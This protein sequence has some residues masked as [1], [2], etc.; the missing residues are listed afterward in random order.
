MNL[1]AKSLVVGLF[2][3][4]SCFGQM[5]LTELQTRVDEASVKARETNMTQ[6]V[7]VPDGEIVRG[8]PGETLTIKS[9]VFVTTPSGVDRSWRL[10][11]QNLQPGQTAILFEEN[12]YG[13]GIRGCS[14]RCS[15]DTTSGI[16]GIKTLGQ[17]KNPL[18]ENCHV[19]FWRMKDCVALQINGHESVIV[20]RFAARASVPIR[21]VGGDNHHLSDLDL[22]AATS[23]QLR[24]EMNEEL[25]STCVWI[26]NMP[27]Q[28]TFG[29]SFTAQGGDHAFYGRVDSTKTG[30]VLRIEGL[31]Y[32]QSLSAFSE[33]KRAIDLVFSNRALERMVL[34][35]C[36][37]GQNRQ[38]GLYV[39]GC[40]RVDD[41]GCYCD[42]TW[43]W[44]RDG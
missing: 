1:V 26:W 10:I 42:G 12:S 2:L 44:R 34:V 31:R 17:T 3:C 21:M 22:T 19:D 30:Q 27:N 13:A 43:W 16:T 23:E 8:L 36:R 15:T 33:D 7:I 14:L 24:T 38:K 5:T 35:G 29:G 18:I 32:E 41:I 37:W 11:V 4:A 9:H 39:I 25:P 20:R 6:A 28:W 40:W